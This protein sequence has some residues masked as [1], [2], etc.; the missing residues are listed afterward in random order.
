MKY[1]EKKSTFWIYI[2]RALFGER[3]YKKEM[4]NGL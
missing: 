4:E 1:F 3:G 2:Q